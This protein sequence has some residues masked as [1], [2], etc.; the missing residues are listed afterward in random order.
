MS[1]NERAQ[2]DNYFTALTDAVEPQVLA[3]GTAAVRH[4]VRRRRRIATSATV[5]A[6]LVL[7]SGPIAG[8]AALNRGPA[9]PPPIAPGESAPATPTAAPSTA[10]TRPQATAAVPPTSASTTTAPDGRISRKDLLAAKVSIPAWPRTADCSTK[11]IKLA[12][13]TGGAISRV[14]LESIA[15][16]DADGDGATETI[17]QLACYYGEAAQRQAVVFDRDASGA[18]LAGRLVTATAGDTDNLRAVEPATPTGVRVK[19]ADAQLCCGGSAEYP[20]TQWRTYTWTGTEFA[21]SGGPRAFGPNP[22]LT[23]L[24]VRATDVTFTGR[25]G[26]RR[27]TITV[28]VDN[29][30]PGR[31]TYAMIDLG[32]PG[33]EAGGDERLVEDGTG[34]N[35]CRKKD[36]STQEGNF[37]CAIAVPPVGKRVTVTLGLRD[38]GTGALP[39]AGEVWVEAVG[40]TGGTMPGKVDSNNSAKFTMR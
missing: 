2:L 14:V 7:I 34:W 17:T 23:D 4:T 27:G 3:P 10:P 28:T 24:A 21:Q 22:N 11:K 32:F 9:P 20:Q 37:S 15:Y 19:V 18:I 36:V 1:D 12:G 8:Y 16:G 5:A 33:V 40:S 35:G 38:T 30:G 13:G 26:A 39:A 25:E 6:A 29:K 31:P